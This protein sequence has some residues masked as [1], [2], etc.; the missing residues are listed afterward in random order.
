VHQ[1]TAAE[2]T[3]LMLQAAGH[4][5]DN[6]FGNFDQSQPVPISSGTDADGDQ[7]KIEAAIATLGKETQTVWQWDSAG[8]GNQIQ[9]PAQITTV[10]DDHRTYVL[11]EIPGSAAATA[12]L[13][14]VR[15]GLDPVLVPFVVPGLDARRAFAAYA[16]SEPVPLTAQILLANGAELAEW[17]QA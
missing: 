4:S 16:F 8:F 7:W 13:R 10:V 5:G 6:N 14:V 17:P 2:W 11:A 3:G 9:H 12:E 1:I 15:D